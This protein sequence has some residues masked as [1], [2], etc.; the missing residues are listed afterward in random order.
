[1]AETPPDPGLDCP[2]QACLQLL[3]SRIDSVETALLFRGTVQCLSLALVLALERVF[4]GVS[5]V[6]RV[7]SACHWETPG[8]RTNLETMN[9]T[10]I[11][12]RNAPW[13]LVHLVKNQP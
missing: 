2:F 9:M 10:K 8:V 5:V 6:I 11:E 1:M 12:S 13:W 4:Y 7:I 3:G